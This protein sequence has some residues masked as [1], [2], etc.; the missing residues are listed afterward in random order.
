MHLVGHRNYPVFRGGSVHGLSCLSLPQNSF[1]SSDR[2][3][4][5]KKADP[6]VMILRAPLSS[7]NAREGSRWPQNKHAMRQ[8]KTRAFWS[9]F[10]QSCDC[11]HLRHFGARLAGIGCS[12]L[13]E[14]DFLH[15]QRCR[16]AGREIPTAHPFLE[17]IL[18]FA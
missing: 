10:V 6:S 1:S 4:K 3:E 15:I 17:G 18:N 2:T 13:A 8:N 9:G 5:E 11:R 14:N 12:P 16:K 7:I